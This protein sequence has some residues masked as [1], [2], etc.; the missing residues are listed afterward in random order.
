MSHLWP[1]SG[2]MM[3]SPPDVFQHT[4]MLFRD[5]CPPRRVYGGAAAAQMQ[6]KNE[7]LLLRARRRMDVHR[8]TLSGLRSQTNTR[9][10]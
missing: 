10:S 1:V 2:S 4:L 8:N 3:D 9:V 6:K 5:A 7:M